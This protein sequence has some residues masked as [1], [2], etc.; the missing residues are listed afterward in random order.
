MNASVEAGEQLVVEIFVRDL[1]ASAAF[2]RDLGFAEMRR[3][4]TF[5]VMRFDESLLFLAQRNPLGDVPK[6]P[7]VSVRVIVPNV[8]ERWA[9]AQTAGLSVIE[10]LA[11]RDY[12][13]RDF[14]LADPDGIGVRFGAFLK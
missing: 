7:A 9:K 6:Q 13:L 2:Y 3:T 12:G 10:P 5:A 1:A 11:D 4:P 8:N 14:T